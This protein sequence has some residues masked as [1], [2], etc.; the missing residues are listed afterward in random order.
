MKERIGSAAL[1][2]VATSLA[3]VAAALASP[4]AAHDYFFEDFAGPTLD[5]TR[6]DASQVV[7][8]V[9]WC[10]STVWDH[11]SNPGEW[12]DV[13]TTPCQGVQQAAPYG[14]VTFVSEAATTVASFSS[15]YP[16]FTFPYLFAGP[17]HPRSPFP[18]VGDFVLEIRMRYDGLSGHGDGIFVTGWADP[19]PAGD[20]P[21][22]PRDQG[23]YG[24]WGD[25][26]IAQPVGVWRTYRLEYRAGVYTASIDDEQQGGSWA[27]ALRPASLWIGNP[28]FTFWGAYSW[29]PFTIDY[30]RVSI[31]QVDA[32]VDV[33]PSDCPNTLD[34]KASGA[35][36]VAIV[37]TATL[38]VTSIDPASL[39]L[40]GVAPLQSRI[41]DVA[42]PALPLLGK[43]PADCTAAGPDGVPDLQLKFDAAAVVRALG[44]ISNGDVRTLKV[45][46]MLKAE[47]GGTAIGGEDVV[48]IVAP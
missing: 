18:P 17:G 15:A 42:T 21:P 36:P 34:A 23:V 37:G 33:K 11:H 16:S 29:S 5:A 7:S 10:S 45:T 9:R 44:S 47:A 43:S 46:G 4:A 25:S 48:L 30:V 20:N 2:A 32:A 12:V 19:T 35:L 6:W 40:E 41:E 14:T 13:T 8:G 31:P 26:S 1:R 28:V 22:S 27:S 38:D 39:R 3:L 24:I